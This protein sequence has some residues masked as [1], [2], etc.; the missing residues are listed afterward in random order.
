MKRI[1]LGLLLLGG[2]LQTAHA[3][4]ALDITGGGVPNFCAG[5]NCTIGWS[6]SVSSPITVDALGLW[7]QDSNGLGEVHDVGLWTNA[8]ILLTSTTVTNASTPVASAYSGGRWLFQD[9]TDVVLGAGTYRIGALYSNL[10]PDLNRALVGSGSVTTIP[11]VA[12]GDAYV[13]FN[14]N[15]AFPTDNAS[16]ANAGVFGPN[17]L[18]TNAP[19]LPEPSSIALLA[20]GALGM[21]LVRRQ[22]TPL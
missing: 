21:S 13:V 4:L 12:L 6:F 19:P 9:I 1:L 7:D 15:L 20:L 8:G 16:A 11:E 14:P 5:G 22:R 2:I 10:S 3:G 17:F 18:T